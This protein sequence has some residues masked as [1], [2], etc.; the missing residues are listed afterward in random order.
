MR[1][2]INS[3]KFLLFSLII[4]SCEERVELDYIEFTPGSLANN[5][6]KIIYANVD[7]YPL[8]DVISTDTP[9]VD[10]S[11]NTGLVFSIDT[12]KAP[13]ESSFDYSK[14]SVFY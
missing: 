2:I 12:V 10:N 9:S 3:F 13:T 4:F 8:L 7:V 1:H 14:F 6:G 11:I 5:D